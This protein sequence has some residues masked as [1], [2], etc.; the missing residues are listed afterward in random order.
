MDMENDLELERCD[1]EL[2]KI[3]ERRKKILERKNRRIRQIRERQLKDKEAWVKKVIPLLDRTLQEKVGSLFWYVCT[4][5]DFCDGVAQ[6]E[7]PKRTGDALDGSEIA[8]AVA[9][10]KDSRKKGDIHAEKPAVGR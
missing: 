3:D 10:E 4:P 9:S 6:M 5:E 1:E 8:A 7:L 2:R